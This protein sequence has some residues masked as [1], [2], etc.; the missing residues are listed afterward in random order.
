MPVL[1]IDTNVLGKDRP[2]SS[3]AVTRLLDESR[4]GRVVVRLSELVVR[5]L[6]NCW[7]E[8]VGEW[9]RKRQEAL[10][11]LANRGV[12]IDAAWIG[13]LDL[14]LLAK[15]ENARV[16][17]VLDDAG[18]HVVGYPDVG[19]EPMIERALARRQPFDRAGHEGY[20]DAI[21]W[22]TVL[23]LAALDEIF[24][25]TKDGK[26]F[27]E[28]R[29]L[30]NGLS[31]ALR[32]DL[33]DRGQ[34]GDR[35]RLFPDIDAALDVALEHVDTAAELKDERDRQERTEEA[36]RRRL[37]ADGVLRD[38]LEQSLREALMFRSLGS[39]M[40]RYGLS[41]EV[42]DAAV[43]MVADV[44]T[45]ELTGVHRT[46]QGEL[47]CDLVTIITADVELE[48]HP[49]A[50]TILDEEHQALAFDF[51]LGTPHATAS[52]R[53]RLRVAVEATVDEGT[54]AVHALTVRS[55]DP[56]VD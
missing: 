21:L 4:R 56:V 26:A 30:G 1:T 11:A 44:G 50:T 43:D 3:N 31:V 25:V 16:R 5:E 9:E 13:G 15:E 23:E 47:L 40:R 29:K 18:V 12:D 39:E 41:A 32:R 52:T 34:T 28:E 33:E 8:A 37:A 19:H 46:S 45:F 35:V 7:I 53:L 42:Y 36:L 49:A 2:F 48:L 54:D 24:F 20:R 22:E 38:A 17:R 10:R 51:R 14:P 27:C 55:L 6:V